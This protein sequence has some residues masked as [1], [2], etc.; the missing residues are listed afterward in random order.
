MDIS[1][2]TEKVITFIRD[3]YQE[4]SAFIPI[5]RPLFAQKEKEYLANAIDSGWVSAQGDFL[6]KAERYL[7]EYTG[8]KHCVLTNSGTSALHI[9]LELADVQPDT[10]VITQ[11]LT[12]V[13]TANAISYLNAHPIFVDV[14]MDTLGMSPESLLE[15]LETNVQITE[16][17]AV[18]K[19]SGRR[20]SACVPMHSLG[21]PC[22]ID[23]IGAICREYH[24]PLVEDAAEALGTVYRNKYVG[25]FGQTGIYSFNGNKTVTSGGGGAIVT[26]DD[27]IAAKARHIITTAKQKD[28]WEYIH[29]QRGYNFRMP[30]L[31]AALLLAQL[32]SLDSFLEEKRLLAQSYS[33]LC[34]EVDLNFIHEPRGSRSNYWLNAILLD[35]YEERQQFLK[36]TNDQGVMTRPIW[37]LMTD[38]PMYKNCQRSS[39]SNSMELVSR[40]VNLP[41]SVRAVKD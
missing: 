27:Q 35:D 11:S 14:E 41:S 20:I 19:I 6:D 26:D 25:T 22:R 30:N 2:K 5:H 34:D 40:L 37:K 9:G 36:D 21:F 38:L 10:D 17:G 28:S 32:E 4:P 15:F 33:R 16:E 18:N 29:D 12:F 31:N 7:A 8:A 13:A 3:W 1:N 23:R 24:I 39:L